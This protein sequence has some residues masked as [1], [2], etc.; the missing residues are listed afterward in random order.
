MPDCRTKN[1]DEQPEASTLPLS[2]LDIADSLPA[3]G[4]AT[5]LTCG[6]GVL[7]KPFA[8]MQEQRDHFKTDWHRL[9]VKRKVA[10]QAAVSEDVCERM[11]SHQRAGEDDDASSL[12][13]SG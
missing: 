4:H 7:D 13:G 1:V 3:D 10:G 2:N 11:L 5:C 12:S 6:V 9:N 8:S